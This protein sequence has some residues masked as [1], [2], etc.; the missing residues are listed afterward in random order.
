MRGTSATLLAVG[1]AGLNQAPDEEKAF[2]SIHAHLIELMSAVGR[3]WIDIYFLRI[4]GPLQEHQ[5]SGALSAL[6]DAREDGVIR[7][8]GVYVEGS[9]HAT[10]LIWQ[11]NDAFELALL[12]PQHVETLRDLAV[13]R[14]AG[15]VLAFPTPDE[16]KSIEAA[17]SLLR[18]RSRAEVEEL[19]GV[20]A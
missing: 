16:R 11:F 2:A 13:E 12:P 20:R 1:G 8:V 4:R 5:I 7:H 18:V 6:T 3:D 10:R 15:I 14:R 19:D 17:A 9:P